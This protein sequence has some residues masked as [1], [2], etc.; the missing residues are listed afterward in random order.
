MG[1]S[2]ETIEAVAIKMR[3]DVQ[4]E[5]DVFHETMFWARPQALATLRR[6]RL[7]ETF[8]P[9]PEGGA[10]YGAHAGEGVFNHSRRCVRNVTGTWYYSR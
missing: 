10:S 2:R 7:V 4:C 1:V 6:L 9:A 8:T 5:F 3:G